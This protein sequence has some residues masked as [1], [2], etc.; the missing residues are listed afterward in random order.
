M[1][2]SSSKI[3]CAALVTASLGA[4][5]AGLTASSTTLSPEIDGKVDAQIWS[6][7][8]PITVRDGVSD[9]NITLKA[10]HDDQHLYL[11]A[12]F[13]D[14][15]E[16]RLQKPLKW[17]E[18]LGIYTLGNEREDT[19]VLKWN[20]S[21]SQ[22]DLTLKSNVGYLADVWFWKANR[23]DPVG[24]ADDKIQVY[25]QRHTKGGKP[26]LSENGT[27]FYLTRKGDIGK[28]SYKQVLKAGFEGGVLPGYENVVPEG[29]RADIAAKGHWENGL[30]TV[31]FK[32]KLSTG[33]SDDVQLDLNKEA[34]FAVSRYEVAG[35]KVNPKLS[36][37]L[38]GAGEVGEIIQLTFD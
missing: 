32:R 37:P 8:A 27:L 16:S 11:L 7:A 4:Q 29:S 22:T 10:L 13:P 19:L 24:Y 25:S 23:T 3:V 2:N 31:E 15:D 6:E 38:Y 21:D 30:W 17:D 20:M 5:A 34:F 18:E 26:L 9:V 12:Q 36:Q 1:N 33:N 35:R 28:S 14:P